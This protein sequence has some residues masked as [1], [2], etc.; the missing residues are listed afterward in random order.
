M[1][2]ELSTQ[3]IQYYIIQRP[4]TALTVTLTGHALM[5]TLLE[6]IASERSA[7]LKRKMFGVS[8]GGELGHLSAVWKISSWLMVF[9]DY[10]KIGCMYWSKSF[11]I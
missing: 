1:G 5:A 2:L 3:H 10:F 11:F 6:Y 7:A 4:S 8:D 9:L